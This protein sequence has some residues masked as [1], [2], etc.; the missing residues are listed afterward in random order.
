VF[1]GTATDGPL[2]Q[3]VPVNPD[4]V[5]L[6]FG[7]VLNDN[8]VPNGAS[9]IPAFEDAWAAGQRDIRLM[10]VTGTSAV[11]SLA[12]TPYSETTQE[13]IV[14]DLGGAVG[15]GNT[16]AHFVL[17]HGGIEAAS[18]E[19]KANGVLVPATG[20]TLTVGDSIAQAEVL[21]NENVT[22]MEADIT[23]SYTYADAEG[24][25]VQVVDNNTDSAGNPMVAHGIEQVITLQFVAKEGAK[26]YVRNAELNDSS[27]FAVAG[28]QLTVFPTK[29]VRLGDKLELAYAYDKFTII[30]PTIELESGFGGSV[31]NDLGVNVEQSA[32]VTIVTIS[33]PESKKSIANEA[34]MTFSSVDYPTFQL[35]VNAINTHS[36]NGGIVKAKTNFNDQFSSTLQ[37]KPVTPFSGGKDEL[38]LSKEELYKRLGGEKDA[39][40]YTVSQGAYQLLENYSVD[41]V[42]PLG[43]F[44]DDKLVGKYDNFAYQLAL[45]CAVMSH[46][47]EVTIGLIN[48]STPNDVSLASIEAHVKKL[49]ALENLYYMRDTYGNLLKDAEGNLFDLGQFIQVIAGPDFVVNNS[50]LGQIAADSSSA[51]VG[52]VSKLPVQSAPTNKVVPSVVGLRFAYSTSQINRLTKNRFVTFRYKPNGQVG[53]VDSM[54]AAHAGS[55]YTRLSTAR[56]V[57]E[58][59]NAVREVADPFIG[60]PND[61]ANRNALTSAV[62]KRLGKMVEA[63]ALL[64]FEF[65]LIVSPQMELLGEGDI[66]LGLHAPNELRRLTTVVSLQ[67]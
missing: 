50:R 31:Y 40:G 10:R 20:Y 64:G 30:N 65:S 17:P 19:L 53:V 22:D 35:L 46:Y 6:I 21:L 2:F 61:A 23:V 28:N 62:D 9:L 7:K 25:Q 5:N 41:Y 4:T 49:E 48:T 34:A 3:P 37:V 11:A 43:V 24:T 60:E 18:F 42:Y 52:M 33:K 51:Y 55:D 57:K 45:A 27:V 66:E 13:N 16:V 67:S 14:D 59:V 44:A 47:N 15:R 8:G 54:T 26:L 32:G 1:L 56:I 12:G 58:A 63:K 38:N 29:K 36:L 39:E